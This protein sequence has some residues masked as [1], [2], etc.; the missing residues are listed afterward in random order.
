MQLALRL[1]GLCAAL[2]VP[3]MHP[4]ILTTCCLWLPPGLQA[5]IAGSGDANHVY[6]REVQLEQVVLLGAYL[7]TDNST[8]LPV[9]RKAVLASLAESAAPTAGS[10]RLLADTAAQPLSEQGRFD[11]SWP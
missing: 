7:L 6:R 1:R 10:R 8:Y 3:H 9:A 11:S 5:A 4:R 2:H